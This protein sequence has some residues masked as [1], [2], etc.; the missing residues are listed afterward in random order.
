M[1]Y[2]A[3]CRWRRKQKE[4]KN[5]K[6]VFTK[7][8]KTNCT[9]IN[10]WNSKS[11]FFPVW[12]ITTTFFLYEDSSNSHHENNVNSFFLSSLHRYLLFILS[13]FPSFFSCFILSSFDIGA[14]GNTWILELILWIRDWGF[15]I[16]EINISR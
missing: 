1:H 2:I 10:Q 4:N 14:S 16:N 12:I 8:T 15:D 9:A 7:R 6:I 3:H 13:L 5:K 11:R